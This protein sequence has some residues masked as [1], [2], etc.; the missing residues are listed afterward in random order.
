MS[1]DRTPNPDCPNADQHTPCPDG[2]LAWH[3]WAKA[4]S[5]THRQR[6]CPECGLWK[7]WEPR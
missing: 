6:R 7:I 2:Y 5:R 4:K 3:T 1:S